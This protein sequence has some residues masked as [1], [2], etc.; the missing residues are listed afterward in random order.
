MKG[1]LVPL[2]LFLYIMQLTA[3]DSMPLHRC[4][5]ESE[6]KTIWMIEYDPKKSSRHGNGDDQPDWPQC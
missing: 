5:L 2:F 4:A 3:R 1:A 6:L